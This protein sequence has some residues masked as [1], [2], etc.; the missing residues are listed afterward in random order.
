MR[1]YIAIDFDNP[2]KDYFDKITCSIKKHFTNGSF[3]TRNNFHLTI[4]FIGEVDEVQ[5]DKIKEVLDK[6]VL[7][8]TPFELL[9]GNLGIFTRKKTNILWIGLEENPVL[10]LL[11]KELSTLLKEE[12]IRFYDKVFMPHIT[13]GRR[14]EL[15]SDSIELNTLIQYERISIPVRAITLMASKEEEGKLNGVPIYESKLGVLT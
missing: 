8:I 14:V 11:H 2:V 6:V 10:S 3:T 13:L 9:V 15:T 1:V 12:K 4:R 5:V 7:K